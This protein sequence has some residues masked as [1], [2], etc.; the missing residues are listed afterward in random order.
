MERQRPTT[1]RRHARGI[2]WLE[3]TGTVVLVLGLLVIFTMA[4]NTLAEARRDSDARCRLR[5]AA[6][7]ELSRVRVGSAIVAE[8]MSDDGRVELRTDAT[9]GTGEW[10]GFTLV[11]VT[12][13]MQTWNA[14]WAEVRLAA[15]VPAA[16]VRR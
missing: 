14:R 10:E 12:A 7:S 9:A 3:L 1:G 5:L 6:E 15:Y 11:T 13:R 2:V 16:E 4:V 8:R